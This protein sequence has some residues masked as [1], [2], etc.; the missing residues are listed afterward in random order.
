VLH[1][2]FL[3]S[4]SY[5]IAVSLLLIGTAKATLMDGMLPIYPHAAP[6]GFKFGNPN[7][8]KALKVGFGIFADSSDSTATVDLWYQR[9]LPKS[10]SRESA[11]G[12]TT[13]VKFSC[14]NDNVLGIRPYQGKT[15]IM[16]LAPTDINRAR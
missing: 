9:N 13:A 16:I 7:I 8:D 15:R 14:P 3:H 6:V 2:R 4:I 1:A 5:G 12:N 11:R 10:C